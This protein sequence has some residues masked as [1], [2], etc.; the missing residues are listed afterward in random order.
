MKDVKLAY[1]KWAQTYEA[2]SKLN[3]ATETEKYLIIPVLKPQKKDLILDI[4][5]GTGRF[6]MLLA[7]RCRKVTGID[8]SPDMLAVAK[9][10][11]KNIKNIE[12]LKLDASKKLPFKNSSFDKV[13][14]TLVVMHIKDL[15]KFLSEIHRV[16][17]KG[18]VLVYDDFIADIKKGFKAKLETNVLQKMNKQGFKVYSWHGVNEHVSKMH[19]LDFN[20]EKII[21][22]RIDSRIR[23]TLTESTYRNNKG[24]TFMVIFKAKK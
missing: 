17:K 12:Y 18:G 16:L 7:K 5:C 20:L 6:A 8:F 19:R 10:K 3:P 23:H 24:R 9:D 13:L 2:D 11:S 1:K 4:G 22:T 14:C 21:F 15:Q